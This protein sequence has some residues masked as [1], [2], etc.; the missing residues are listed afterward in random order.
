MRTRPWRFALTA[1]VLGSLACGGVAVEPQSHLQAVCDAAGVEVSTGLE[2]AQADIPF[3]AVEVGAYIRVEPA[4][5]FIDDWNEAPA[6]ELESK[7]KDLVGSRGTDRP[8]L[9][10][11]AADTPMSELI[12][13]LRAVRSAGLDS[14]GIVVHTPDVPELPP[15]PNEA[16]AEELKARLDGAA[17]PSTRA[18][19]AAQELETLVTLCPGAVQTFSAVASASADTKCTLI[20]YGLGEALPNCVLTDGDKVV[21]AVQ[22]LMMPPEAGART[23]LTVALGEGDALPADGVWRDHVAWVVAHRGASISL[24]APAP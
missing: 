17:D 18:T 9:L 13:V 12:A 21:T 1:V 8:L 3:E 6:S 2:L 15:F 11:V 10:G 5:V 16:Y 20:A 7:V 14:V 19:L 24:P 23:A 4:G 22:V